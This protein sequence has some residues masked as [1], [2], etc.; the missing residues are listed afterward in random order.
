LLKY[1]NNIINE[2]Q[3]VMKKLFATFCSLI[4]FV[5]PSIAQ[6]DHDFSDWDRAPVVTVNISK[7]QVPAAVV[8]S[9]NTQ[10]SKNKPVTWS[11]FPYALKTYGWVYDVRAEKQNLDHYAIRMKTEKG[12][13]LWAV[14]TNKGELI[15]S[16]EM[17]EN[18][19]VPASVKDA[20]LKSKY[21][22][23]KIVGNKEIIRFY[24]DQNN[25]NVE[26]H[27]RI[28]VEKDG[29]KR[30]ISFNWQRTY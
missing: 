17:S 3:A 9:V 2:N 16:R 8:N 24:N 30:S 22:D 29:I 6:V 5:L 11:K 21:K 27:F 18:I 10:F 19:P 28:T 20:Y 23:W 13:D 12:N 14:F 4:T 15:E 1:Q 7:D 26:Q 25:S